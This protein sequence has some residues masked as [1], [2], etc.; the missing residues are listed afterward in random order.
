MLHLHSATQAD[1]EAMTLRQPEHVRKVQRGKRLHFVCR[2]LREAG[3]PEARIGMLLRQAEFG[4]PVVGPVPRS[5]VFASTRSQE[6]FD[7]DAERA[8]QEEAFRAQPVT[9]RSAPSHHTDA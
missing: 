5:H 7:E 2:L 1:D 3:A 6:D 4:I 8:A 9:T